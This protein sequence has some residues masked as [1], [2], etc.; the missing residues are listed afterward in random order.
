MKVKLKDI[1]LGEIQQLCKKH[2]DSC[3]E[4][5]LRHFCIKHLDTNVDGT[6]PSDDWD[7]E[8]EIDL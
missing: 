8:K 7:L 3:L 5:P 6:Y 2:E 4:C 1:T